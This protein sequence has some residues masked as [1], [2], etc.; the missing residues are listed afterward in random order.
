[1]LSIA[2]SRDGREVATGSA[3]KAVKRWDVSTGRETETLN[4]HDGPVQCIE[5]SDDGTRLA[6]GSSD[7][8]VKL[9][10]INAQYSNVREQL[11]AKIRQR[12]LI[13]LRDKSNAP[14]LALAFSPG[15]KTL[16]MSTS[17]NENTVRLW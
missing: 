12:E 9:W 8:T 14:I 6:T 1:M 16:A 2:F 17:T 7:G 5:Y 3:D 10:D 4:G 15:G 13:T 11:W